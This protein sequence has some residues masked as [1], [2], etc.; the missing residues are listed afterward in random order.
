MLSD[1]TVKKLSF[2]NGFYTYRADGDEIYFKL[3]SVPTLEG[4]DN[5]TAAYGFVTRDGIGEIYGSGGILCSIPLN[6]LEFTELTEGS[7]DIFDEVRYY[8]ETEF[9]NLSFFSDSVFYIVFPVI[10]HT[11]PYRLVGKTIEDLITEYGTT[12][13]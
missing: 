7:G 5:V 1:G 12:A 3:N 8:I 4:Y 6:E 11:D 13:E 2:N 9:G 10:G